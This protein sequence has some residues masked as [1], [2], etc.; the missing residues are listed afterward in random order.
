MP[1]LLVMGKCGCP[2]GTRCIR[3]FNGTLCLDRGLVRDYVSSRASAT[4]QSSETD[5][6][7]GTV[8]TDGRSDV[9]GA[10]DGS[11]GDSMTLPVNV[12][13]SIYLF[14]RG[15][16]ASNTKC[17]RSMTAS[18]M[19]PTVD[20]SAPSPD[21][22]T[23]SR[24][25]TSKIIPEVDASASMENLTV[26]SSPL[27]SLSPFQGRSSEAIDVLRRAVEEERVGIHVLTWYRLHLMRFR[28]DTIWL[29][30]KVAGHGRN[31]ASR[32]L[33][34]YFYSSLSC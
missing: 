24:V 15:P 2:R 34:Y 17:T 33:L 6:K 31:L 19:V 32:Y 21:N 3:S 22:L 26:P 29:P 7:V 1:Y 10:I 9:D 18:K 25:S 14:I 16:T 8:G 27:P 20:T 28:A 23:A 5:F 11:G 30:P 13:A 12:N 4:R